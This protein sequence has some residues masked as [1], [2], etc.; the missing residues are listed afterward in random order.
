MEIVKELLVQPSIDINN[1]A[2]LSGYDLNILRKQEIEKRDKA[3]QQENIIKSCR[4][5]KRQ[6][7]ALFN[8][9]LIAFLP[10][11]KIMAPNLANFLDCKTIIQTFTKEELQSLQECIDVVIYGSDMEQ[12]MTALAWDTQKS[13]QILF[14][15]HQSTGDLVP[16]KASCVE[17][18]KK[19]IDS[20]SQEER[21]ELFEK[22]DQYKER[23][24][25]ID[26]NEQ[27]IPE[28]NIID[29][30]MDYCLN[31]MAQKGLDT[32]TSLK[33]MTNDSMR[34]YVIDLLSGSRKSSNPTLSVHEK[35]N[36]MPLNPLKLLCDDS[37]CDMKL[38]VGNKKYKVHK[39]ILASK[40]TYFETLLQ[41][42]HFN[43]ENDIYEE[44]MKYLIQY[45]YRIMDH[46]PQVH[47]IPLVNLAKMH[48]MYDLALVVLRQIE[49]TVESFLSIAACLDEMECDEDKVFVE[50]LTQFAV[51][52]ASRLVNQ[53]TI[54]HIP[55]HI[56]DRIL[57]TLTKH[58]N[59]MTTVSVMLS[60]EWTSRLVLIIWCK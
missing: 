6:D 38:T 52:N 15:L 10:L 17:T 16:L 59:N 3:Q 5:N 12:F 26:R 42:G 2:L 27:N 39:T 25:L 50:K 33:W 55:V 13:M 28:K 23:S 35:P 51:K 58:W 49:L 18:I 29:I 40:S 9:E 7:D 22:L 4:L 53:N 20:C 1:A 8:G 24:K 30:L 37:S 57:L 56:K 34:H 11:L 14:V 19:T 21:A 60:K 43:P 45:C 32:S 54:Q 31:I 41:S 46:V 44:E 36:K 47:Q 48:E